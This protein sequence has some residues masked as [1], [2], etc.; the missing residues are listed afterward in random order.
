M[1][2]CVCVCRIYFKTFEIKHSED[3][4]T[5][6]DNIASS[7]MH[8]YA[9][10]PT[11]YNVWFYTPDFVTVDVVVVVLAKNLLL[12]CTFCVCV[13]YVCIYRVIQEESALL[14]EMIV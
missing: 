9:Y 4:G 5:N 10:S 11:A 1:C 2:V 14:W 7:Y 12:K 3:L 8:K 13:L 6:E